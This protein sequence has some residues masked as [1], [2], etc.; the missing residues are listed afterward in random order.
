MT[1]SILTNILVLMALDVLAQTEIGK[2]A[3]AILVDEWIDNPHQDFKKMEGQAVV[4]DFWF[5]HCAPCVYTIPHLNELAERYKDDSIV[6]VAIT[7]EKRPGIQE[8]LS[9]KIM[10]ANIGVDSTYKTIKAFEVGGYPTTFLI[11]K[12]GILRW[13]GYPSHLDTGLIDVVLEKQYYSKV[14][15][16]E[17]TSV[18]NW[19]SELD[20]EPRYPITISKNNYMEG[21][22]GMQF[23]PTELSIVNQSLD[24][25]LEFL[26]QKS[27]SRILVADMHRYD[28]RFKIPKELSRADVKKAITRALLDELSLEMKIKPKQV[29][30]FDLVLSNDSAFRANAINHRHVY[31]GTGV[32]A[33]RT[34]WKGEGVGVMDLARELENRFGTYITDKTKLNGLFEFRFPHASF[35][36]AKNYLLTTYGLELVPALLHFDITEIR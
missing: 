14:L 9:K 36:S 3:P 28:I 15:T 2:K 24:Q 11:D 31:N 16:F 7:Y 25:V 26:L 32:S 21:A 23:N 12:E 17:S 20:Q 35:D 13:A 4:L 19:V 34:F 18:S 33:G 10:F 5:T 6:F 1:R 27:K 22:S 29:N 8:F 30:G